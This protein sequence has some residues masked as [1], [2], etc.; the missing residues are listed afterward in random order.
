MRE[1]LLPKLVSGDI[2]VSDLVIGSPTED[3][4]A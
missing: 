2:D 1:V 4:A 3:A